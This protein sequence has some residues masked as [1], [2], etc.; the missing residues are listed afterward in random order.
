MS[1]LSV[2]NR[3]LTFLSPTWQRELTAVML[4]R[5]LTPGV[6]LSDLR[7]KKKK[8]WSTLVEA[9]SLA[10]VDAE[11]RGVLPP[12]HGGVGLVGGLGGKQ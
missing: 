4:N 8:E 11:D 5:F 6:H 1:E 12:V 10:L 7:G 9:I 3:F 2:V